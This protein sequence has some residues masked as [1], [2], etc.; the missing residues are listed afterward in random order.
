MLNFQASA[1]ALQAHTEFPHTAGE[2]LDA[3]VVYLG[4]LAKYVDQWFNFGTR[5]LNH[6]KEPKVPINPATG[7]AAKVDDPA[8]AGTF[9]EA[10]AQVGPRGFGRGGGVG[11]HMRTAKTGFVGLDI[12]GVRD[13]DSGDLNEIGA[14]VVRRFAG[15]YVEISP[16]GKGLRVFCLGQAYQAVSPKRDGVKV[17][18]YPGGSHNANWLRTTGALVSGT[19]GVVTECQAGL[20]WVAQVVAG[21]KAAKGEAKA[22][23]PTNGGSEVG[24]VVG[25]AGGEAANDPGIGGA[26]GVAGAGGGGEVAVITSAS[27]RPRWRL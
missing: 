13:P 17:E 14:E 7:G 24:V 5:K 6:D 12:D 9:D 18:I 16:S 27:I 26:V 20:D 23:T 10:V 22:V 2:L 3:Q 8:T 4:A 15:A 19:G 11:V 1:H 25:V 21:W